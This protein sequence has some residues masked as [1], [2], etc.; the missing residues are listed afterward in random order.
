MLRILL[1]L[2]VNRTDLPPVCIRPDQPI[3]LDVGQLAS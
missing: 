3:T 1:R 2:L